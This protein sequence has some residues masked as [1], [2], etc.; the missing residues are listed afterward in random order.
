VGEAEYCGDMYFASPHLLQ[1]RKRRSSF[2]RLPKFTTQSLSDPC[3]G[4]GL[5]S[6]AYVLAQLARHMTL[7]W[8]DGYLEVVR[9]RPYKTVAELNTA[10][11]QMADIKL[12]LSHFCFDGL[13]SVFRDFFDTAISLSSSG[14]FDYMR[15]SSRFGELWESG[16][17]SRC[18]HQLPRGLPPPYGSSFA[19]YP[20]VHCCSCSLLFRPVLQILHRI[21]KL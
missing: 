8:D 6:L 9:H 7:P 5:V 14:F 11:I 20:L 17:I 3:I 10:Y 18:L 16:V 12:R 15:F 13:P 21:A 19:V 2:F 4:D 1:D